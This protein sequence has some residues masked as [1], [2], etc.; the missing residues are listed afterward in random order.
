MVMI[1]IYDVATLLLILAGVFLGMFVLV[2][3]LIGRVFE[4]F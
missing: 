3:W 2:N 4:D 1:Q